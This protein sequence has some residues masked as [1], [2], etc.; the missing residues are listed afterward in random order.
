MEHLF[1]KDFFDIIFRPNFFIKE[2]T[3]RSMSDATRYFVNLIIIHSIVLLFF[4]SL[5]IGKGIIDGILSIFLTLGLMMTSIIVYYLIFSVF[6]VI[7]SRVKDKDIENP[8]KENIVLFYTTTPF[9]LFGSFALI[10]SFL[11]NKESVV[12]KAL[13]YLPNYWIL[14]FVIGLHRLQ[15][16]KMS[17]LLFVALMA[18]MIKIL[19]FPI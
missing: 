13:I 9:F 4:Y 14:L 6:F 1:F 15:R 11:I 8:G 18:L 19:I 16:I 2:I 17:I 10:S 12:Y 3:K 7:I 5:I